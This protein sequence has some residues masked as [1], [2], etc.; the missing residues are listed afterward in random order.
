[1][2][3]HLA[4][5]HFADQHRVGQIS[6]SHLQGGSSGRNATLDHPSSSMLNLSQSGRIAKVDRGRAGS[7]LV[8]FMMQ[9]VAILD[10]RMQW[11]STRCYGLVN[12]LQHSP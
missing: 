11:T 10:H 2:G 8:A 3:E 7:E 12:G 6:A 5:H 4:W 1:M 9:I